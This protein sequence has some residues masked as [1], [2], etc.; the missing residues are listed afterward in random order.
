VKTAITRF[1]SSVMIVYCSAIC[2]AIAATVQPTN[3]LPVATLLPRTAVQLFEQTHTAV[4]AEYV[5]GVPA[6][7]SA[8]PRCQSDLTLRDVYLALIAATTAG[9]EQE[10]TG[11]LA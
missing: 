7:L 2:F 11:L 5:V 8:D 4:Y 1:C 6:G 3:K 10:R 9:H